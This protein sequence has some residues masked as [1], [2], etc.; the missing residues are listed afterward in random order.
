MNRR[1]QSSQPTLRSRPRCSCLLW[2]RYILE[3]KSNFGYPYG[4]ANFDRSGFWRWDLSSR[5]NQ[6]LVVVFFV[7]QLKQA[8]CSSSA[9]YQRNWRAQQIQKNNFILRQVEQLCILNWALSWAC[10][11][12]VHRG[13]P[14]HLGDNGPHDVITPIV[15]S[16]IPSQTIVTLYTSLYGAGPVLSWAKATSFPSL[17]GRHQ[18]F[19]IFHQTYQSVWCVQTGLYSYLWN[20]TL[21]AEILQLQLFL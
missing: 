12:C 19:L 17:S 4:S 1:T 3:L 21:I 2:K 10:M 9:W 14:K 18:Y 8:L 5:C 15:S 11:L 7:K 6:L 16:W 20:A 13:N